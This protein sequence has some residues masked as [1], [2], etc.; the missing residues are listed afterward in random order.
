MNKQHRKCST[1]G[2]VE[3]TFSRTAECSSCAGVRKRAN[4]IAEDKLLLEKLYVDVEATGVS[5]HGKVQWSFTHEDCGTTQT[6]VIGNIK[7]QLSI[8]PEHVPCKKCGGKERQ[9]VAM[10]AWVEKY[11]RTLDLEAWLD[12]RYTVRC[13]TEET[14]KK[15][16]SEINPNGLVRARG[17]LGYH[18][19][20]KMPIHYGFTNGLP[21][22]ELAAKE[23]LQMLPGF[24]NISKGRK[25]LTLQQS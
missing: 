20:H 3:F 16:E 8:R 12:Y 7:K 11:G 21:P 19:D 23:N 17:N 5:A 14:Y 2:N 15:Y 1:C 24:D 25:W 4:S 9:S 6:W 10:A 18:L 13:L 22:E